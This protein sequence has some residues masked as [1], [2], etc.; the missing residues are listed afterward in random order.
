MSRCVSAEYKH[1]V[2]LAAQ[3]RY[4]KKNRRKLRLQNRQYRQEGRGAVWSATYRVKHKDELAAKQK[5]PEARE[6][7][8]KANRAYMR[9][10]RVLISVSDPERYKKYLKDK[11]ERW[12]NEGIKAAARKKIHTPQTLRIYKRLRCRIYNAITGHGGD[13]QGTVRELLGISV[14]EFM[15]YIASKFKNG[16]SWDNYGEWELDHKRPVASFNLTS[17]YD[18]ILCFH[19]TNY[20]PLWRSENRKKA[21]KYRN[22]CVCVYV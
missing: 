8:R 16:M 20:Q 14:S 10:K 13:K 1:A 18:Q 6:Q 22:G 21:T 4:R 15:E 5:T 3:A 2:K 19:Y 11:A 17:H 7:H 12:H 9:K